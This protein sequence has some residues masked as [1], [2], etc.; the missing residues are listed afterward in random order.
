MSIAN[1][2]RYLHARSPARLGLLMALSLS[3]PICSP[4]NAA[5]TATATAAGA[6]ALRRSVT[7]HVS[8]KTFAACLLP[9]PALVCGGRSESSR[10]PEILAGARTKTV[11]E[12]RSKG[13]SGFRRVTTMAAAG[14]ATETVADSL[15]DNPLLSVTDASIPLFDKIEAKH[16]VPGM[17]AILK[18]MESNLD[19]L[20]KNVQP[21]WQGLVEP[22]ERL[23]DRLSLAWGAVSHLNAV[24]S[25]DDLRAA[26]EEVQPEV[27]A[28]SL[29][30]GQSR[31]LYDAF[32]AIRNNEA[33]WASLNVAQKR[34]VESELTSAKTSGVALEGEAKARFNEIKQELAQ[35]GTKFSNN[36]LDSTKAFTRVVTDP[37]DVEG[38]P[39]SALGLAAQTAAAK[40]HEGATAES[41]PWAFTLDIPSYMPLMQHCRNRDLREE[42]YRAYV[43]RASSGDAD[44]AP[45]IT[46]I[47]QLRLEKAQLLGFKTHAEVPMQWRMATL[48]GAQKLVSDLRDAAWDMSVKEFEELKAFAREQGAAEADSLQHWD[49]PF[50][51]ERLREARYELTA[52]QLRPFF[53]LPAVTEG[54]FALATRLFGVKFEPADGEA[55]VWNTD[56][57]YYKVTDASGAVIASFLMDPY[58]RPAEKRGGAWMSGICGRSRLF[59]PAGKD[60]RLPVTHIV[61][62]QTPPVGDKPSLMTFQE[63]E[64]LFHEFGHALQHM[65][66]KQEE[67]MVAGI[68]NVEWDAVELP[69]QFMENWCYHRGTLFG[70]ARHYETGEPLPEELYQKI[71]AAKNFRSASMMMRQLHFTAIDLELHASFDPH[72]S[73]S[74]FDVNRAVAERMLVLPPLEED[75]FLCSFLHIFF[76]S[77]DVGYYGYKW[78]EVLS[79]DAFAAFEEAGLDNDEAVKAT[80][81]RYRDTVLGLGGGKAAKDVFVEFRGR[82]PS[83]EPLLRHN[84]LIP[85]PVPA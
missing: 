35:L 55:P 51:S 56:V 40:G 8:N 42:V 72:G 46:R 74:I 64:T 29:R 82:E 3:M 47:L 38:M 16:V 14:A 2:L 41:G 84:G 65:L 77:Y 66:T 57:R 70:M 32:V 15:T 23:G 44:N 58:S 45:I 83:I 67:G 4:I 5:A 7:R 59:A 78:A 39:P 20:E 71:V 33:L 50:W 68:E 75:R 1:R 69:S 26:Y 10:I 43:T 76:G 85:E 24:K 30:L 12:S 6:S 13:I 25:S 28:L 52:E 11:P 27:V 54:L 37:K 60:A 34:I 19:E 73:Q 31:P 79:A 63:V 48:E 53:S 80:G 21:T 17:R 18:E 81:Q 22:L 36:V 61:C 62:N 9:T 49:V